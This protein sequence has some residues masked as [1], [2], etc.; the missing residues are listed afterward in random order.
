MKDGYKVNKYRNIHEQGNVLTLN[1]YTRGLVD[2]ESLE[3]YRL[4][5]DYCHSVLKELP[6]NE[7]Y[8]LDNSTSLEV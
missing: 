8:Y 4:W 1:S 7:V 3:E 2:E 6:K 5:K